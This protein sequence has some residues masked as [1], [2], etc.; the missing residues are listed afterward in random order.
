MA[1]KK[2]SPDRGQDLSLIRASGSTAR[3]LNLALVFER[4]GQSDE[5][6]AKPLFRNQKLNRALILK[7]AIRAHE[8]A[9]F[10]RPEPHT[11]K[12]VFPYSPTE[13]ELG[14]TSVMVGEGRFPELFR[15]ALGAH[16]SEEDFEADLELVT[17]LHELPSF[18]PFLLR[19]QL[20]RSGHE[21]ARCFFEI[22]DAD[23]ARMLAF[24]QCEIEPLVG[25]AFGAAGRRAEKLAMRL[26]EKLMTDENAQ[27]LAPLRET[28]R[29]SV[30]EFGEGAF[31]WKG[32]LYYKWMLS[33]FDARHA[34]F[35][36]R[37]TGCAIVGDDARARRDVEQLRQ[38]VL[39]RMHLVLGRAGEAILAYD[40]AF[41]ALARGDAVPFRGFLLAAPAQFMPLGE[42]LGA[43]K[44]IHTFWGFR[45]RADAPPRLE[46]EEAAEILQEFDRMLNGIQLVRG[47]LRQEMV[48]DI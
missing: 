41:N 12:I 38:S 11:T 47:G 17:L 6:Q 44:H 14:G 1:A 26:S 33:E 2:Q 48:L 40:H 19:E 34:D 36:A 5:F 43:V 9:L 22:A 10:A 16:A 15:R 35:S 37:F 39:T 29:L 8:R 3:V 25:M 23:I 13:L 27:M 24:V 30:G 45:F 42:A 46:V 32:F 31:A 4:H 21:P 28:L 7:H 18:D 20:K